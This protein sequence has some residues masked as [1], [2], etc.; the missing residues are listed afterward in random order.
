M[1]GNGI[2]RA[3]L[4]PDMSARAIVGQCSGNAG[5]YTAD[6]VYHPAESHALRFFYSQQR[7]G[8]LYHSRAGG[9]LPPATYGGRCC[10]ERDSLF[11][12]VTC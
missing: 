12:E 3:R 6:A 5:E 9:A 4:A 2:V 7:G 8:N 1:A 11:A 10:I